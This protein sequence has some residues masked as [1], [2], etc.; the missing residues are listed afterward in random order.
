MGKI[1][2][3]E[4]STQNALGQLQE[5]A[6]IKSIDSSNNYTELFPLYPCG[7]ESMSM[8]RKDAQTI[9]IFENN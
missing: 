7:T 3:F 4:T 9:E 1:R 2:I 5:A 6:K 8:C